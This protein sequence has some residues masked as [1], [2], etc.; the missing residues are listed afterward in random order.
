MMIYH[1][2]REIQ[3]G[4]GLGSFL[5]GLWRAFL[6]SAKSGLKQSLKATSKILKSPTVKKIGKTALKELTNSAVSV[7]ADAIEGKKINKK[8]I[9]DRLKSARENIAKSVRDTMAKNKKTKSKPGKKKAAAKPR[10]QVKA[11]RGFGKQKK[12]R[13]KAKKKTSKKS[14]TKLPANFRLLV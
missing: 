11:H 9:K 2:G 14:L 5:S 12:L 1:K 7:S 8:V 3:R 13:K 10:K 4:R 6:P